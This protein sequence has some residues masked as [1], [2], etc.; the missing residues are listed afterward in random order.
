MFQARPCI[1]TRKKIFLCRR[2]TAIIG[3]FVVKKPGIVQ[4]ELIVAAAKI[5]GDVSVGANPDRHGLNTWGWVEI[6]RSF[7]GDTIGQ[8]GFEVS[9]HGVSGQ[10]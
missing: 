9:R 1:G 8:V 6:V 10:D 2:G 5:Y 3:N 7:I 4:N